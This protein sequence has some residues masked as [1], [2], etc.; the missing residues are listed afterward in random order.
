MGDCLKGPTRWWPRGG[1]LENQELGPFIQ[2]EL[3]VIKKPEAFWCKIVKSTHGLNP[4]HWH[5][6]RKHWISLRSQWI[7]ISKIWRKFESH[8]VCKLGNGRNIYIWLDGWCLDS[9]FEVCFP[10]LFRIASLWNSSIHEH[11]LHWDPNTRSWN[12]LFRRLLKEE[13][14]AEFQQ[15]MNSLPGK[16]LSHSHDS[17]RSLDSSGKYLVKSLS[18]H[19]ISSSHLD[20]EI[21]QALWESKVLKGSISLFGYCWMVLSIVRPHYRLNSRLIIFHLLSALMLGK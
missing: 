1:K 4:H 13:E 7:S 14:I 12:L 9:P 2:M 6:S 19:L 11:W 5:T 8:A 16:I 18:K 20:K 21:F 15:L 3:E 17:R 10:T